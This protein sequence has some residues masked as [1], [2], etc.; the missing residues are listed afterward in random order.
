MEDEIDSNESPNE[1]LLIA[2]DQIHND[3]VLSQTKA[4]REQMTKCEVISLDQLHNLE[5]VDSNASR[6]LK[7]EGQDSEG[8]WHKLGNMIV[9]NKTEETHREIATTLWTKILEENGPGSLDE[10]LRLRGD[11]ELS[12]YDPFLDVLNSLKTPGAK[13]AV[14]ENC[15]S[16]FKKKFMGI[17]HHFGGRRYYN[18]CP[19]FFNLIV[20]FRCLNIL[21]PRDLHRYYTSCVGLTHRKKKKL[22]LVIDCIKYKIYLQIPNVNQKKLLVKIM[23]LKLLLLNTKKEL[24][25]PANY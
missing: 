24:L 19:I 2:D 7:I 4:Q 8:E 5:Q 22:D 10:I 14:K 9:R 6:I 18:E 21:K 13:K 23:P 16:H 20:E 1:R 12:L 11:F 3:F 15:D 17:M 25:Q